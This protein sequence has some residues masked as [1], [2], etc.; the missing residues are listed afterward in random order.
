MK[1]GVYETLTYFLR[2]GL[3]PNLELTGLARLASQ[4]SP[5]LP[6]VSLPLGAGATGA[7]YLARLFKSVQGIQI[8]VLM[9]VHQALCTLNHLVALTFLSREN[10]QLFVPSLT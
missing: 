8:Q 7:C 1:E 10:F 2:Q 6:L 9:I 4:A 5:H 3:P